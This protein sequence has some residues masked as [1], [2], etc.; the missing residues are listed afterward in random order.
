MFVWISSM[1]GGGGGTGGSRSTTSLTSPS[2]SR[3]FLPCCLPTPALV[4]LTW[5][6]CYIRPPDV[7][8]IFVTTQMEC[9]FNS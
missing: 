6:Y 4:P 7:D 2:A 1:L 8:L 9:P 3:I 5:L